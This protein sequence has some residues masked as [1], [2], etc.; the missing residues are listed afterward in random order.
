MSSLPHCLVL[1]VLTVIVGLA[2]G[3]DVFVDFQLGTVQ[4]MS[5][6]FIENKFIN[7]STKI[8]V[9]KGI[10]YA[11]PPSRYRA[12]VAKQSWSGVFNATAYGASCE[13]YDNLPAI[14]AMYTY[15]EDCLFLNIFA[16]NQTTGKMPVMVFIHGGGYTSGSSMA[17]YYSGI[18]LASVGDVILVTINYRL[19]VTGFLDTG[20]AASPGNYGLLDQAE[21]LRWVRNNIE[22]FGG[23]SSK[24]T[25]FGESAGAGSVDFHLVS[26]FSRDLFDQ[27]ILESGAVLTPWSFNEYWE[28]NKVNEAFRLGRSVNCSSTDTTELV[29]CLRQIDA[30]TL[31]NIASAN[32]IRFGPTVDGTFLD[33]SPITMIQRGDFKDCP[34]IV[35]FNR[36]EGTL[37][38]LTSFPD[39]ALTE[40]APVINQSSFNMLVTVSQTIY[41]PVRY[42]IVEDSIKQQYVDWAHWDDTNH[43]Y[44]DTIVGISGD[45]SFSCPCLKVARDRAMMTSH[46]V[47]L[48][49]FTQVPTTSVFIVYGNG[50]G[51]LGAGHAE[52]LQYVFGFPFIPGRQEW[53]GPMTDSEAELSVKFMQF[54][55][56]FA[57]SGDPSRPD[58]NSSPG[59]GDWEWPA[60]TIPELQYKELASEMSVD[61]G[62][63]ADECAFWDGFKPDL[64]SYIASM[65]TAELEWREE[66]SGWQKDLEDW[67]MA[68]Q[69]YQED[70][71]CNP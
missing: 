49:F 60:F 70:P 54:W 19:G 28:S 9:F 61:R 12:P 24:V 20:D 38:I 63:K 51:W 35:G 34:V 15:S 23:D 56:N 41:N 40:E 50:P 64:T 43:D 5:V 6:D 17:D 21:A 36:D 32:Q 3:E 1:A 37:L 62:L 65:D 52:E 58:S 30:R 71:V 67:R 10:P 25:I 46:P 33:E 7:K 57:K 13:Q 68:F 47:Y 53:H 29:D 16:P 45:E 4:G 22:A 27:A 59:Q 69:E 55:T 66:F 8:N 44:F 18:P 26:K 14:D 2:T 48:Y 39:Y 11:E 42:E 31:E